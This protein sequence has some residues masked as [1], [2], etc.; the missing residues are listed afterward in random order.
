LIQKI[1]RLNPLLCPKCSGSMKIIS[2]IDQ[3]DLIQRILRHLGLWDT[4]NHDPP[5]KIAVHIPE[6]TY[7][8]SYS[9]LPPGDY[10][11]Q[12][13]SKK[14]LRP[15]GNPRSNSAEKSTFA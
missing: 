15:I 12:Q 2:F 7:D 8:D 5:S 11:L 14:A 9:Q 4:R 6:L 3:D 1:Y 10:W 13:Q